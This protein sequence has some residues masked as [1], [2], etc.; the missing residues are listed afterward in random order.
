MNQQAK[1]QIEGG[2]LLAKIKKQLNNLCKP[3]TDLANID[4]KAE[5]LLLKTGGKPSFKMVP[6]YHWSTCININDGI[7]H[8]IPKGLL[9]SGD[10]V[11]LDI[12]LF[13]QGF[14]T[15]TSSSFLI[16]NGT[17]SAQQ[18]LQVGKKTLQ[19]A[20]SQ[21]KVGNRV[22]DIS[23]TIQQG[24]EAAGFSVVRNLT[25]HG[26]GEQLHQ[27]PAI[28]CFTVGSK[29]NSPILTKD[30]AIAIELMYCQGNWATKTDEDDWTISTE[31]GLLSAVFEETVII[32]KG[33]PIVT[34][35]IS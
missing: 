11:T 34:T 21:A 18:F 28:P 4:K 19:Q 12:G 32:T 23:E 7:V 31:D 6:G 35:S 27:E 2:R 5:K 22:W 16:G 25:G 17:K 30:Q 20:I 3:G 9:K 10:L 26:V 8:G 15:D 33:K 13:Y 24:V 1:A 14:H 29:T